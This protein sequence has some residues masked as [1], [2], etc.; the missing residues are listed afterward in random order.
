MID[1]ES[2]R[3]SLLLLYGSV[4]DIL[5]S[6]E[7]KVDAWFMDGFTPSLNPEMG[8][9]NILVEIARLCRPNT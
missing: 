9:A 3:V 2:G 1:L 4:L 7:E 8:L 6:L 5:A